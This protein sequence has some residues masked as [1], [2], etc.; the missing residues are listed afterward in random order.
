[1]YLKNLTLRGFKSFASK[2]ELILEPG[3][4]CIVGPNGSGKSNIVD[5]LAWVMGEQG[6]KTL[7]GAKMDDVIFAGS[8]GKSTALGRAEVSL[9]IDNSDGLLPIEYTEVT[10][11]RTMF[12]GGGSEYEINGETCRLLDIQE[13]LSDTGLGREMHVIVGQGR[14][15]TILNATPSDRRGFIE[16]AAGVLKHRKRKEKALRKLD[17]MQANLTRLADLSA[18]V[19]RQ[20]GPLG[21][22]ADV[23]KRANTIQSDVRDASSRLLA[24]DYVQLERQKTYG[25]SSIK[26]L[27]A[28]QDKLQNVSSMLQDEIAK[29]EEQ[30]TSEGVTKIAEIVYKFEGLTQR[31]ESLI[32][33]ADQRTQ[34][35]TE[36]PLLYEGQDPKKLFAIAKDASNQQKEFAKSLEKLHKQLETM[37]KSLSDATEKAEQASQKVQILRQDS[38]A[39][40][41]R[42]AKIE[43]QLEASKARQQ[44]IEASIKANT[45][46][47]EETQA[48]VSELKRQGQELEKAL[49]AVDTSIKKLSTA[50]QA[51]QK[52]FDDS[53]SALENDMRREVEIKNGVASATATIS[54]LSKTLSAQLGENIELVSKKV[55][56]PETVASLRKA[57]SVVDAISQEVGDDFVLASNSQVANIIAERS[58]DFSVLSLDG[59]LLYHEDA[60]GN[61]IEIDTQTASIRERIAEAKLNL[62]QWEND[63]QAHDKLIEKLK[64]E[65]QNAQEALKS[66]QAE[67]DAKSKEQNTLH[68]D[69]QLCENRLQS[70]VAEHERARVGVESSEKLLA[71]EQE[72]AKKLDLELG[73]LSNSNDTSSEELQNAID[74]AAA[75]EVNLASV[76]EEYQKLS[77]QV[78]SGDAQNESML[79]RVAELERQAKAEQEARIAQDA[80][81]KIRRE[82]AARASKIIEFAKGVLLVLEKATQK[83]TQTRKE[84]VEQQTAS[85]ETLTK[86]RLDLRAKRKEI[87][88]LADQI[89]RA[90]MEF[91]TLDARSAALTQQINSELTVNPRDLVKEYGPEVPILIPNLED[92]DK[93][94]EKPYVRHEQESR[95][96]KAQ[97]DLNALGKVNPLA[98]EEFEAL[99]ERH[100]YLAGQLVDI[101]KSRADLIEMIA[102]IDERTINTFTS[103][104]EDTAKEFEKV[105]AV[106][107]PGGKGS[108]RLTDPSD[109]L[110]TGIEV[111]ATPAGKRISHLSLL[112][113]GERSL[114]AVAMLVAIFK[115]RPSPFYVMDEVEAALDDVNLS[116]L[117]KIFKEL[118]QSSQILI[119]TH[120]K[121]TM[122]VADALYGITMRKD[123]ITQVISQKLEQEA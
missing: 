82:Q 61:K 69:F 56:K 98:L 78:A 70:L 28:E 117:L 5:A 84:M 22:Q 62:K 25:V 48:S 79:V 45:T 33:L 53:T 24:D 35:L 118:R 8:D 18:E 17:G 109:L 4:T 58:S 91:A 21:R 121:R 101:E 93:P 115:A 120:Q 14:L 74:V 20:L 85:N 36:S 89:H 41:E 12:R 51:A 67:F 76:R 86:M 29:L 1:L 72:I 6:A 55:S 65:S 57:K 26:K 39:R 106:L 60:G 88:T 44:D 10:I 7:R 19:R 9:T 46:H 116:R 52:R 63:L 122:E 66:A 42:S 114:V 92:P 104:F 99:E 43:A 73:Q 95:L 81:E 103:A 23:A 3:I 2:T 75:S 94:I 71:K 112:S 119:V 59:E 16:E 105:F 107:F 32:N 90:E 83:A 102:Q 96:K 30:L 97:R 111:H 87:D 34:F 64:K 49:K 37:Q 100:K 15:D 54:A 110:N 113:G 77:N 80:Q 27:Q 40:R 50:T 13:L 38:G 11:K 47:D 31:C 123:G 108:L 68:S